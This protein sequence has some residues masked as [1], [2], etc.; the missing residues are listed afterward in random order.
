VMSWMLIAV[1]LCL[2]DLVRLAAVEDGGRVVRSCFPDRTEEIFTELVR[3]RYGRA[4]TLLFCG[5]LLSTVWIVTV[6][7][8]SFWV[9]SWLLNRATASI[10]QRLNLPVAAE[11]Q[12]SPEIG[13]EIARIPAYV[14]VVAW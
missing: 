2:G 13:E 12:L 10:E 1:A 7:R 9:W 3:R 14:T 4:W 8:R 6:R 5:G 11:A